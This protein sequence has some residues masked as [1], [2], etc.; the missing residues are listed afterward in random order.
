MV[1]A[2]NQDA[3]A[4]PAW[5][6]GP[7]RPWGN[8]NPGWD[9]RP[10]GGPNWRPNGDPGAGQGWVPPFWRPVGLSRPA[11]I[12]FTI[13]GF[14]FWWPVGLAM[15]F[16]TLGSRRMGCFGRNRDEY[17]AQRDAWK[18]QKNAWKAW[19][20]GDAP[21][22]ASQSSGNRAFDEYKAETLRRMEEEQKEFGSFLERLRF[23]KDKAEFDAFMAER[24]GRPPAPPEDATSAA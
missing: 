12:A 23:A 15:L 21:P 2:A 20:R 8:P 10:S 6:P 7:N 13:L 1:S 9:D 16:Y 14:M 4:N 5:G 3:Y 18:E 19:Y 17:R 22:Q 11:A 24:R